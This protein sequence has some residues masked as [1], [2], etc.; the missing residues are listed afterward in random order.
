[1]DFET[2]WAELSG[3]AMKRVYGRAPVANVCVYDH[4]D[5]EALSTRID[6]LETLLQLFTTHTN[7]V[8]IDSEDRIQKG[9]PA[10]AAILRECKPG[11]VSSTAWRSLTSAAA[12]AFVRDR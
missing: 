8:A 10:I 11:G 9:P 6:L 1:V 2:Q 4:S 12:L 7:V 3:N 5:I